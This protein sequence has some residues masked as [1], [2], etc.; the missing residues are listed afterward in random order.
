M[1][2]KGIYPKLSLHWI[3]E[4]SNSRLVL[5][6]MEVKEVKVITGPD[7]K[8]MMSTEGKRADKDR[9]KSMDPSQTIITAPR[10]DD[11]NVALKRLSLLTSDVLPT[12]CISA[13]CQMPDLMPWCLI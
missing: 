3:S 11:L 13:Q 8:R 4:M 5:K 6:P 9:E 10:G 1:V 7:R 2:A 12:T